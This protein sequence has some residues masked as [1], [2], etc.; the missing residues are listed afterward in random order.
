MN[1]SALQADFDVIDKNKDGFLTW[2]E[3]AVGAGVSEVEA[4]SLVEFFDYDG[5]G[6]LNFPE[7]VTMQKVFMKEDTGA[8][9]MS[10]VA[11]A[12]RAWDKDGSGTLEIAELNKLKSALK[13]DDD[14]W[15]N[16][17]TRCD[18]N[19]D[20]LIS[21]REFKLMCQEINRHQGKLGAAPTTSQPNSRTWPAVPQAASTSVSAAPISA[22]SARTISDSAPASVSKSGQGSSTATGAQAT[23]GATAV[24]T[25]QERSQ[26]SVERALVPDAS[27]WPVVLMCL[28]IPV[29]ALVVF[30]L[31]KQ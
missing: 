29:S 2:E 21:R 25:S 10:A 18:I 13:L 17:V 3:I 11:S 16:I 23:W 27:A 8:V 4:K 5:D 15:R 7:F 12:F 1:N 19:K 14:V 26:V 6:V 30:R 9:E 31:I 28:L 20:G 24:T 22:A